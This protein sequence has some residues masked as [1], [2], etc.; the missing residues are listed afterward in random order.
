MNKK[1]HEVDYREVIRCY[2]E[3]IKLDPGYIDAWNNMGLAYIEKYTWAKK[4]D[5]EKAIKCFSKALEYSEKDNNTS[6]NRNDIADIYNNLGLCH[7]ELE[8]YDKVRAYFDKALEIDGSF[9][10]ARDNKVITIK[11]YGEKAKA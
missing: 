3:A 6:F 9:S 5:F 8:D 1:D 4:H 7:F 10:I 11:K 2:D